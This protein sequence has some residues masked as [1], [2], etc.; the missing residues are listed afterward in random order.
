[1]AKSKTKAELFDELLNAY[2]TLFTLLERIKPIV[3]AELE[4]KQRA[5][6]SKN[7]Q[8]SRLK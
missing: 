7:F 4:S 2:C 1:M 8:N 6:S 5:Y 3:M